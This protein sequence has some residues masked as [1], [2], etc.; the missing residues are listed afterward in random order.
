LWNIF[1][2]Q[3]NYLKNILKYSGYETYESIVKLKEKEELEQVFE[4]VKCMSD[5]VPDIEEMFGIFSRNPQNTM[6]IPGL[7]VIKMI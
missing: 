5:V 2:P 1:P 7:K 4:F 3:S 6:L